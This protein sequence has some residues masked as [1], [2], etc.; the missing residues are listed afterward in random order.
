VATPSADGVGHT[1]LKQPINIVLIA[2]QSRRLKTAAL[3]NAVTV[4]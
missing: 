1:D 2:R 3:V 4:K